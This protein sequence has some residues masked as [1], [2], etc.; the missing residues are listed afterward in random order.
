MLRISGGWFSVRLICELDGFFRFL[1][2]R[3]I[4]ECVLYAQ[5]YGMLNLYIYVKEKQCLYFIY[6]F[7]DIVP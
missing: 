3:L 6:A 5:I 7:V 1:E 4:R 2:V